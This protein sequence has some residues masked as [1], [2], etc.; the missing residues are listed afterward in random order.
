MRLEPTFTNRELQYDCYLKMDIVSTF[1]K[2]RRD[3]VCFPVISKNV[4]EE[5]GYS[6]KD[7]KSLL[8]DSQTILMIS[9]FET[10]MEDL[11]I[12]SANFLAKE[13][14]D[15]RK[16]PKVLLKA[17]AKQIQS[18]KHELSIWDLA[19]DGWKTKYVEYVKT[20]IQR[21]NSPRAGNLDTLIESTIGLNNISHN[22]HWKG[23]KYESAQKK[24]SKIIAE[25]GAIVHRLDRRQ[26]YTFTTNIRNFKFMG[27]LCV[28]SSNSIRRHLISLT[29]KPP[30]T[31]VTGE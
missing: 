14:D 28:L 20:K 10:F 31:H 25:R 29:G 3:I 30:W 27:T 12:N 6:V 8:V 7:Q 22:W 17:C 5:N 2:L 21:L 15:P 13:L 18:E 24:L 1:K 9:M 19:G 16:L 4:A 23:M 11:V 26:N